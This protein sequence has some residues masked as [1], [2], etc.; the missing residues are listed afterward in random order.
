M[1]H[2]DDDLAP[3]AI[4]G[5]D[6]RI[7]VGHRQ[8]RDQIGS[9]ATPKRIEGEACLSDSQL[10]IASPELVPCSAAKCCR[11]ATILHKLAPYC[12]KHALALLANGEPLDCRTDYVRPMLILA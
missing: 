11:R 2:V 12:G 5:A 10:R 4:D 9:C 7:K 8:Y 3:R 6:G 1:A